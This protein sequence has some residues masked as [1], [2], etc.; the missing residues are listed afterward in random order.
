MSRASWRQKGFSPKKAHSDALLLELEERDLLEP[1][2]AL[3]LRRHVLVGHILSPIRTDDVVRARDEFWSM[4]RDFGFRLTV[5]GRLTGG[6]DHTSVREGLH[7]HSIRSV[8]A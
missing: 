4:L 2:R 8:A 7:R 3:A 1:L 5:I 6:H